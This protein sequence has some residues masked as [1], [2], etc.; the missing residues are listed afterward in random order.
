MSTGDQLNT[1]LFIHANQEQI[2]CDREHTQYT[3]G[4]RSRQHQGLKELTVPH[5]W[6]IVREV[7]DEGV[8]KRVEDNANSEENHHQQRD[9][10]LNYRA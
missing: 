7:Q 8:I 5:A 4:K 9:N 6:W 2:T 3:V 10:K 1:L